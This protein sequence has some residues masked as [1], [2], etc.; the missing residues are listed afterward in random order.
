[1][2][3]ESEMHCPIQNVLDYCAGK[4]STDAAAEFERHMNVCAECKAFALSQQ[5]VWQALDAWE[6]KP[7]S[8]DFD[9][10]LHARI[11]ELEERTWW[12]G[13]WWRGRWKPAL[14]FG[15][16]CAAIA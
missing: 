12:R 5:H 13:R 2:G 11:E 6:A 4:L 14:S 1:M 9:R 10:K 7:V 3:E 16:A 15:T 8:K